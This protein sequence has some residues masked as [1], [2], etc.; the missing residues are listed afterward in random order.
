MSSYVSFYVKK[1]NEYVSLKSVSGSTAL[2]QVCYRDIPYEKLVKVDKNDLD[3]IIDDLIEQK[4]NAQNN[5]KDYNRLIEQ[6]K[7]F[8]NTVEAKIDIINEYNVSIHD[9]EE[10]IEYI[11][12]AIN[13]IQDLK[14]MLVEY[15]YDSK[16]K[17]GLYI[18]YDTGVD[19]SDEDIAKGTEEKTEKD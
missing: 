11:D 12:Y 7:G 3:R 16:S 14:D 8:D 6:V 17:I 1:N 13:F 9:E 19:V 18:G 2:Y 15:K 5:I 4:I 10:S